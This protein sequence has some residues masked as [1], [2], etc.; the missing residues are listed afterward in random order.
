MNRNNAL[1]KQSE[2]EVVE[3]EFLYTE[4]NI[5]IQYH[6]SRKLVKCIGGI[7]SEK[8]FELIQ[9]LI[10]SRDIGK[11]DT[12]FYYTK[13]NYNVVLL[14]RGK[15]IKSILRKKRSTYKASFSTILKQQQ[16]NA[17]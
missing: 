2:S 13:A 8:S 6:K 15:H 1:R 12:I 4:Q 7:Q 11:I 14:I 16:E 9:E 5:F 3:F 10:I 17:P